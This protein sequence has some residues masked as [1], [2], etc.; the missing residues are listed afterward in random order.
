ML[1]NPLPQPLL[2]SHQ[3]PDPSSSQEKRI[4]FLKITLIYESFS[5][6]LASMNLLG[7]DSLYLRE[8]REPN[9]CLVL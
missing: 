9:E 1:V 3:L 6:E 5:Y 2:R 7:R 4:S 8:F